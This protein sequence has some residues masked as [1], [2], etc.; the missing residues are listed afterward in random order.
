MKLLSTYWSPCPSGRVEAKS[1]LSGSWG[2]SKPSFQWNGHIDFHS[3]STSLHSCQQW[4][5]LALPPCQPELSF[6]L[7]ILAIPVMTMTM[8]VSTMVMESQSLFD[9]HFLMAKDG[10]SVSQPVEI[11]QLRI[12]FRSLPHF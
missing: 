5:S 2:I 6:V 8:T 11:P 9:L 12:L 3:G 1:G 4:S 10:L 7:L